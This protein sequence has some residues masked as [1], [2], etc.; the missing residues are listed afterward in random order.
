MA[1]PV[2]A[3]RRTPAR[4]TVGVG[5]GPR[6]GRDD[7]AR[8]PAPRRRPPGAGRGSH[9]D[10]PWPSREAQDGVTIGLEDIFGTGG[11]TGTTDHGGH[12]ER[13]YEPPE[14]LPVEVRA[15]GEPSWQVREPV[16]LPH[17]LPETGADLLRLLGAVA[18][19]ERR[20]VSR[21]LLRIRP[22]RLAEAVK[23]YA[24][25]GDPTWG[26]GV[27][28]AVELLRREDWEPIARSLLSDPEPGV[29]IAAAAGLSRV[30]GVVTLKT[31]QNLL[32]DEEP[33][34]RVAAVRALAR[35]AISAGRGHIARYALQ[36]ILSDPEPAVADAVELALVDLE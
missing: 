15:S 12:E 14:L 29:R 18:P 2:E 4:R 9:P 32:K 33:L 3:S 24:A 31:L 22:E 35:C 8:A 1:P 16:P 20:D 7:G 30:G 26:R 17:P 6:V 23:G 11:P 34:V 5:P 28:L 27:G 36:P 19:V 21:Q 10:D 25:G 13:P